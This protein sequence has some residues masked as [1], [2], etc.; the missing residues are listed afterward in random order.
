M[1]SRDVTCF[2]LV[3]L[4]PVRYIF[5]GCLFYYVIAPCYSN[6]EVLLIKDYS[7]L[8]GDVL[9]TAPGSI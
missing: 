5:M 4:V 8:V 1:F 7:F 2:Y 6:H 9:G 3:F